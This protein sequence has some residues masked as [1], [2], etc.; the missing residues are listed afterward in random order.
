MSKYPQTKAE[1]FHF[2]GHPIPPKDFSFDTSPHFYCHFFAYYKLCMN[3][4][5]KKEVARPL[6]VARIIYP[7]LYLPGDTPYS[8]LNIS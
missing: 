2:M 4:P 5:Y 8:R 3:L 6:F 7:F 1:T